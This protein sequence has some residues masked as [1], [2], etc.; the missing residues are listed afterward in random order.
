MRT[1]SGRFRK[2]WQVAYGAMGATIFKLMSTK[3]CFFPDGP[4][5]C[6][7]RGPM[8]ALAAPLT[9]THCIPSLAAASA[10]LFNC[11]GGISP[12]CQSVSQFLKPFRPRP[13]FFPVAADGR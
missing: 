2:N 1:D 13:R 12:V 3:D 8:T 10:L 4:T 9:N 6:L 5:C 7:S 11:Q